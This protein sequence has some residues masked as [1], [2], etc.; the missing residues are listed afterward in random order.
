MT[1]RNSTAHDLRTSAGGRAY[2]AE[3]F[4]TVLRRHDFARYIESTLA[5]DFACALAEH[6]SR[7]RAPVATAN[8][9]RVKLKSRREME[10]TI[11]SER[12]GW[13][14]DVS[15]RQQMVLRDATVADLNRCVLRE[16]DTRGP[17]H[18]LCELEPDGAL[19]PREAVEHCRTIVMPV[20]ALTS[21]HAVD[22]QDRTAIS[23]FLTDVMTAA[24]LVAH[25]KQCK[26]LA[27]R[28]GKACMDLRLSGLLVSAPVA[29][30]RTAEH[31]ATLQRMR[32]DYNPGNGPASELKAAAL[33]AAIAA[34]ASAPVAN[35]APE[36][37]YS[38]DGKTVTMTNADRAPSYRGSAPVACDHK[39]YYFGD[40]VKERRCNRCNV[41]ESKASAPVAGEAQ[42]HYDEVKATLQGAHRFM[43]SLSAIERRVGPI[44]SHARGYTHKITAALRHLDALHA[45]PQASAEPLVRYCPGC[46]SIGPVESKYRDCC[47]DGNQARMIPAGLAEKCR[48]TFKV[49]INGMLADAAA[50]DSG[51]PCS[52]PSGDG[53]L[54]WPC[55]A[56]PQPPELPNNDPETDA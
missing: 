30:E 41:L 37:A 38:D 20:A 1:N 54:R 19:V 15:P 21:A 8:I 53:S 48:D 3:Y 45:A 13:W 55:A 26:A 33:D 7:L 34:M 29:D 42:E 46:G 56:H 39:F 32:A 18:F 50:N 11:P 40:Q 51:A 23:Q 36:Y 43:E 27:D 14:R 47:P 44:G 16:G 24:G 17:E 35:A 2:V 31:I 25:G 49:A 12:M 10:R 6:L 52:C 4:T 9:H 5:A 28:L 22:E